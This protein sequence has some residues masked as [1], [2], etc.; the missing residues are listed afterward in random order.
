M[1]LSIPVED[2]CVVSSFLVIMN[3]VA[4]H[5]YVQMLC[6]HSFHYSW[7]NTL[8]RT[9]VSDG[10]RMFNFVRN[11]LMFVKSGY[12]DLHFFVCVLDFILLFLFY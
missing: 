6:E 3:R 11:C 5:I 12:T 2:V 7:L 8:A 10:K 9:D 4:V 1:C